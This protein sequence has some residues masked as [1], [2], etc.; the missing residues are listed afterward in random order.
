MTEVVKLK[1][2]ELEGMLA[3]LEEGVLDAV[4]GNPRVVDHAIYMIRAAGGVT[5]ER[6]GRL[7]T[8]LLQASLALKA[9]PTLDAVTRRPYTR[10]FK[11]TYHPDA[12][13]LGSLSD[14][15]LLCGAFLLFCC[16]AGVAHHRVTPKRKGYRTT[17]DPQM[18][19]LYRELE[20]RGP[21]LFS[22]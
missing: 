21:S 22:D 1:V 8:T 19:M 5:R 13:Y 3:N 16:W 14:P 6:L 10:A 20:L 2:N 12:E 15:E 17:V 7:S 11:A 18:K 4:L 9:Y